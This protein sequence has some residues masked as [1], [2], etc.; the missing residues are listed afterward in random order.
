MVR[1]ILLEDEPVLLQELS[2][3]LGK[4]GYRVDATSNIQAFEAVFRPGEHLIALID[5]GLPDGDGLDFIRQ[6]REK[7]EKLGIIVLTAR[8]TMSSKA[9]GLLGGAD[10]YLTKPFNLDEVASTIAALARRLTMGSL[11]I[12]WLISMR[13]RELT[14]PGGQPIPLTAQ[15][16]QVLK[17]IAAGGGQ[18]VDRRKI[19]ADLGEDYLQYDQRRLDTQIHQ[20]RKQV[21]EACGKELPVRS[22]RGRGYQTTTLIQLQE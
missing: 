18:I 4:A 12:D 10:H 16:Y 22:A 17:S 2:A 14:P 5:L 3:F 20:L 19:V 21:L 15:G 8:A 1:L 11:S 7:G 13:R 9:A 6:L